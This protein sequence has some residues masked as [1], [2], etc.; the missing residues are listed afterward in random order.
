MARND[1]Y[2][3]TVKFEGK[4]K[5]QEQIPKGRRCFYYPLTRTLLCEKC[6]EKAAAEFEAARADEAFMNGGY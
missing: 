4:C 3:L 2:W 1:P 5:C 6:S